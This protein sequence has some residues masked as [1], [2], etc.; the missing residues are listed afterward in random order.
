[1]IIVVGGV[2]TPE[3]YSAWRRGF[4]TISALISSLFVCLGSRINVRFSGC[5]ASVPWTD[6]VL[7]AS[8]TSLG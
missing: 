3:V 7:K 2:R 5:L 1:M 4:E 6:G 8:G